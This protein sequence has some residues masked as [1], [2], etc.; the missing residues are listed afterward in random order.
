M[1]IL[2]IDQGTTGTTAILYNKQGQITAKAYREFTQIYPQPGWVEHD[3]EEIWQTVVATVTEVVQTNPVKIAGIGITNQ[4]ETT[5][6]WDRNSGKPVHN[7]IVWQCRRTAEICEKLQVQAPV[8]RAKSGLPLDA[9]FSGTKVKWLLENTEAIDQK[10][11]LFGTIDSWLI[12]KLTGGKMHATDFTNASRTLLYNIHDKKWDEQLCSLLNIPFAILPSV[13][14]SI[15]NY[16][17]VTTI[18]QIAGLPICGVAGDQQAALFGQACFSPGQLKNTYGTGCFIMMNTGKTAVS[19]NKGLLT[20]LAVDDTGEPCYALEGSVFIAGAAIQWLRDEL[21]ILAHASDSEAAALAVENNG[22]VYLVPAFVGLGAPHWNMQ[23]RGTIVGLTRGA[24]RNHLIRAALESMAYQTN[25]VLHLIELESK[26]NTPE[27]AVDGGACAN[28]F[29]MQF[30]ADICD[31]SIARPVVIEST[32]LG[33]AYLA[34][35]YT[36]VWRNTAELADLKT[37]ERRFSPAMS[38]NERQKL[39]SGWHKA[40]RQTMAQ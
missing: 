34:G 2:A 38:G 39:L 35:L 9:Y 37:I 19:S 31:K 18:P 14:K 8:F 40:L 13:K 12:W 23:A 7:A 24:N 29:L 21:K 32:S 28:N 27:L 4:R 1:H 30:Q 5:V 36:G 15:D 17:E 3:A 10:N 22:G 11:V 20:T 26:M 16:G 33:A 25:D 6:L